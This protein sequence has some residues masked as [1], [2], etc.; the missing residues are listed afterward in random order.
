MQGSHRVPAL[1]S[2]RWLRLERFSPLLPGTHERMDF[3]DEDDDRATRIFHFL[4]NRLH[5]LA[6]CST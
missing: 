3:I 1:S 2:A 4:F 6:E 5:T